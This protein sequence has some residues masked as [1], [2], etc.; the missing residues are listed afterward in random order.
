METVLISLN[1]KQQE[2]DKN[3][4]PYFEDQI[5]HGNIRITRNGYEW[6]ENYIEKLL[7][8]NRML[9]YLVGGNKLLYW[10]YKAKIN[11]YWKLGI[12]K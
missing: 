2:W 8:N 11:L 1:G 9:H 5:R 10:F 7:V 12:F 6:N 4:I 3:D